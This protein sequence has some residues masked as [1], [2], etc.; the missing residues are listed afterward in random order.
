MP[1]NTNGACGT[2]GV[3]CTLCAATSPCTNKQCSGVGCGPGSC[4]GCCDGATCEPGNTL[5]VCGKGGIACQV[6]ATYQLCGNQCDLDPDSTWGVTVVDAEILKPPLGK[7]WD[8]GSFPGFIEPDVYVEAKSGT[9]SGKT[10]TEDNTQTP[11]WNKQ[12]FV[13]KAS[14]LQQSLNLK[15]VDEDPVPPDQTIG[16]CTEPIAAAE[17]VVGARIV[18]N[19]GGADVVKINLTF[20]AQ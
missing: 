13:A 16:Q 10:G 8:P 11:F 2:G 4:A 20:T 6:C 5:T 14:E 12:V 1:G 17:L 3:A 9:Q 15:V 7:D 18:S 19:C